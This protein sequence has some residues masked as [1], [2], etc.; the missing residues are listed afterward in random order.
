MVHNLLYMETSTIHSADAD[1]QTHG[2]VYRQSLCSCHASRIAPVLSI[3]T[4]VSRIITH[5]HNMPWKT[6][7]VN[8]YADLSSCVLNG[9]V[10][11]PQEYR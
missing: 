9:L 1:D 4:A 10:R 2:C 3:H 11:N 7:L 5:Q 8:R 6:V